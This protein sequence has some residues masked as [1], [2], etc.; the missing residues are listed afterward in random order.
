MQKKKITSK[1]RLETGFPVTRGSLALGSYQGHVDARWLKDGRS[2]RLLRPFTFTDPR[3]R[4][5]PA[6]EDAV[7]NGADIPPILCGLMNGSPFWGKFRKASVIHDWFCKKKN[8]HLAK[9]EDVHLMFYEAMLCS[10]VG[11]VKAWRMYEAVYYLG[12][13]WNE[14]GTDILPEVESDEG[15]EYS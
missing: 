7:I 1:R 5:W 13:R 3:G 11:R 12:P 9:W 4:V 14:D 2:M 6:P 8:R 10:G 15:D